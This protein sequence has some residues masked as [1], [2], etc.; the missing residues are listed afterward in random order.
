M[1]G[2]ARHRRL[3]YRRANMTER[4]CEASRHRTDSENHA[5]IEEVDI[6]AVSQEVSHEYS[7]TQTYRTLA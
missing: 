4:C 1:G 6:A 2:I 5:S 3:G 7:Y